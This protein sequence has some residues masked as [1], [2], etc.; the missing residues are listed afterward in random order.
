MTTRTY[1]SPYDVSTNAHFQAAGSELS[2]NL[3]GAGLIQTADAGQINWST[4]VPNGGNPNIFIGYE[5]W[6]LPD[7]SLHIRLDY[8]QAGSQQFGIQVTVGTGSDGNGNLTGTTSSASPTWSGY[9]I[10]SINNLAYTTYICVTNDFLGV[11]HKAN[12]TLGNPGNKHSGAFF[13]GKTTDANGAGNGVGFYLIAQHSGAGN[14]WTLENV[15]TSGTNPRS[16]GQNVWYSVVPS[17]L[18]SSVTDEG[19][20]QAFQ[21]WLTMPQVL[22]CMHMATVIRTEVPFG[23]V[24]QT[25]MVGTTPHSYMAVYDNEGTPFATNGSNYGPAMLWE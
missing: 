16:L 14:Q 13:V 7:G 20:Q 12:S 15:K 22:P 18:V 6:S 9:S 24:F 19:D 25:A 10:G 8:N 5:M 3:A 1:S 23:T 2:S 21:V 11:I 17:A 4:A